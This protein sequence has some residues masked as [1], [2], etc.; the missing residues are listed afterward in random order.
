MTRQTV[1]QGAH[2]TAKSRTDT[3]DFTNCVSCRMTGCS[4]LPDMWLRLK[5]PCRFRM[6][7]QDMNTFF[8]LLSDLK[9]N[10]PACNG[11]RP[12]ASAGTSERRL[13][14]SRDIPGAG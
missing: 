5:R 14:I 11:P 9:L 12:S 7:F 4:N 13:P 1:P 8:Q 2:T 10:A 3:S 6:D